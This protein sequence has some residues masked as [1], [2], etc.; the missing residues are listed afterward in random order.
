VSE[1]EGVATR[2]AIGL[3][4]GYQRL[5]AGRTSPCRSVPSCSSYA[6]E[7]LHTHGVVRGV[8]LAV[9]RIARCNP[10]GPV[11]FDPVPVGQLRGD[12]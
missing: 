9:R 11:G 5:S 8:S 3:V 2:G 1:R 7:A 12:R 4:R 10:W 6:V